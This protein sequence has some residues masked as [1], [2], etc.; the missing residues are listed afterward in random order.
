MKINRIGPRNLKTAFAVFICMMISKIL[1]LEYPFFVAIAAI[2]SMENSLSNSFIAGRSRMMGTV[3]GAGFGLVCALIKPGDAILCSIGIIGVIYCCNLL[4]W[5]KPVAFAGVVFMAVMVSLNGRN[6]L[7]YSLNRILDTFIGIIVAAIINY[8]V[9]P[10][11]YLPKIHR[12]ISK[13]SLKTE[14]IIKDLLLMK[15]INLIEY[16]Q[17]LAEVNELFQRSSRDEQIH[18][19]PK[20]SRENVAISEIQKQLTGFN[21]LLL[22][23]QIINQIPYQSDLNPANSQKIKITPKW[24]ISTSRSFS[25]S[26]IDIIFNYH[27]QEI[28]SLYQDIHG[29]S[30]I[31]LVDY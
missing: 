7:S 1:K 27:I 5:H 6:P 3:I 10:P 30:T 19:P 17:E 22:H 31:T 12:T 18:F 16:E 14:Q 23:F 24:N 8:F 15:S 4:K 9:F 2:I 21:Q 26:E 11:D 13:L 29:L 28:L 25:N 20:K